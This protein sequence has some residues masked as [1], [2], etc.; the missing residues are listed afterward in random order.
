MSKFAYGCNPTPAI[1][2]IMFGSI[3]S[4]VSISILADTSSHTINTY[5][6]PEVT[7]I[8]DFRYYFRYLTFISASDAA[9]RGVYDGPFC[10]PSRF[11]TNI[12]TTFSLSLFI[13]SSLLEAFHSSLVLY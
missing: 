6:L 1:F 4:T 3:F 2:S 10:D 8:F 9:I 13:Y 12:G 7:I 5:F 11:E